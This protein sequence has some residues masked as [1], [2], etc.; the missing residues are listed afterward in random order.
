VDTRVWHRDDELVVQLDA[1]P[2]GARATPDEVSIGGGTD[3]LHRPWQQLF[4]FAVTHVLAHHDRYVLHAAGLVDE[5]GHAHVVLG[6]TGSGKSTLA[7][8]AA[9]AG[10]RVLGDDLVVVRRVPSGLEASGIARRVALPGDLGAVL[11]VATPRIEGDHRGRRE[12]D[13]AHLCRGW[14]PVGSVVEVGHSSSPVGELSPLCGEPA[15]YRV[16]G[17]FSSVT[18]PQLVT[19]FFPVAG[20]LCQLPRWHLGH[21]ADVATRLRAGQRLLEELSRA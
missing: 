11:D 20:A 2:F 5:H 1:A 12:L 17:S 16:L 3:E 4:H 21:G 19:R 6:D 10:W 9:A 15:L 18:D 8:A 7:L 14:F 13:V